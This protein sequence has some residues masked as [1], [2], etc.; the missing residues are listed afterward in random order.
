MFYLYR[1]IRHDK[2]EPFYIGIGRTRNYERAFRKTSRNKFWKNIV[3]KT[4]YSVEILYECETL[5]EINSKEV[6]FIKLYGRK[7][8]G[9]G[10]LV[11]LT[12][13]GDGTVGIKKTLEQRKAISERNTGYKHTAEAI[14]KIRFH[15]KNISEET[16][17]KMSESRKGKKRNFSEEA[18]E[19]LRFH[20][21][22]MHK[23]RKALKNGTTL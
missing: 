9:T 12:D 4:T 21:R 7:D 13:G 1:H 3:S 8:L 23:K 14:E 18:L 10:S 16:R 11:N 20:A 2:N 5:E 19:S 15:A 6:E 22:E 17:R